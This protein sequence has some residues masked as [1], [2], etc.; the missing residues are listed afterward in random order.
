MKTVLKASLLAIIFSMAFISCKNDDDE[1]LSAQYN[2]I[3]TDG[4]LSGKIVNIV[5]GEV[6]AIKVVGDDDNV[7][8]TCSIESDGSFSVTLPTMPIGSLIKIRDLWDLGDDFIGTIS[9]ESTKVSSDGINLVAY[10]NN[11]EI[12]CV[13][14]S[15]YFSESS[16]EKEG[17][18]YSGFFYSDRLLKIAGKGGST[19]YLNQ[20]DGTT[21]SETVIENC[22]FTLRKGWNELT[23][24]TLKAINTH[25]VV[26]FQFSISDTITSDMKW[27]YFPR[28]AESVKSHK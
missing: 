3:T 17:S 6:D 7:I 21:C 10:K 16:E 19:V 12:G 5:S 18:V 2:S 23:N 22:N 25:L 14:K 27:R 4:V 28:S 11:V 9:D 1:P 15:N 20:W 24:K 26:D 8:G 13:W